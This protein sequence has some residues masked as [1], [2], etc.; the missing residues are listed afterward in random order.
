M[1]DVAEVLDY[2]HEQGLVHR[3]LKP[4]NLI[5]DADGRPHL[6]DLGLVLDENVRWQHAR[7]LAGTVCYMAP[8]QARGDAHRLDGRADIWALGVILYQLLTGRLPFSGMGPDQVS[9][10]L[11]EILHRDPK[12]PRQYDKA[13]PLE[14]ERICLQC[15][16]KPVVAR[17]ATAADLARDLRHWR[18]PRRSRRRIAYALGVAL[19]LLLA[20]GYAAWTRVWRTQDVPAPLTGTLDV[21]VWNNRVPGRQAV[22][23]ADPGTLP[24]RPHD[25]IQIAVKLDR[26]AYVYLIAVSSRFAGH[27]RLSVAQRELVRVARRGNADGQ[28]VAARVGQ[29]R[30]GTSAA[31][32]RRDV[33]AAGKRHTAPPRPR[34]PRP[35]NGPAAPDDCRSPPRDLVAHGKPLLKDLDATRGFDFQRSRPIDDSLLQL[36]QRF[37]QQLGSRCEFSR[38]VT[39]ASQPGEP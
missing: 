30:L 9:Q 10:V 11:D 31:A 25:K 4:Q 24:L 28:A 19:L 26:P 6:V 22:L 39:F 17:Y 13:I 21:L 20:V 2:V 1:A 5:L 15:L 27:S 34:F 7:E 37:E 14:L 35:V 36:H 23:L 16:S 38:A 8:E 33:C 32:W 3:D 29:P 18:R 12:P